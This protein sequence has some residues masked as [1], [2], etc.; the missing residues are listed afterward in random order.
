MHS[1]DILY[2]IEHIESGMTKIGITSDWF[3]RSN[4]LKVHQ[5]TR[6][7]GLFEAEDVEEAE[8]ELHHA[9]KKYRLPGSEY[10]LLN[11]SQKEELLSKARENYAET[12]DLTGT[13]ARMMA[14][15]HVDVTNAMWRSASDWLRLNR[16]SWKRYITDYGPD[17]FDET[18]NDQRLVFEEQMQEMAKEIKA[19]WGDGES[20]QR[21]AEIISRE[22]FSNHSFSLDKKLFRK[23]RKF[24]SGFYFSM[25]EKVEEDLLGHL[26]ISP[27]LVEADIRVRDIKVKKETLQILLRLWTDYRGARYCNEAMTSLVDKKR[28]SYY[29]S[30][31]GPI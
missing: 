16:N 10:F 14:E 15:T 5:K 13:Y 29:L 17:L 28:F 20:M 26:T 25:K 22:V 2:V 11:S 12:E 31:L 3:S 30:C 8:K 4:T 23:S 21:A 19:A 24:Y 27:C 1:Q 9:F 6:L 18:T 7:I